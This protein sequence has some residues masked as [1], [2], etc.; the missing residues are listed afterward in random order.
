MI[1]LHT[2][3]CLSDGLLSPLELV[4][5]ASDNGVKVMAITDH[6]AI[7][8]IDAA[9]ARA[10]E[11]GITLVNGI[12][13]SVAEHTHIIGLFIKDF[14]YIQKISKIRGDYMRESLS[15][16][17][18]C[19][20]DNPI[21]LKSARDDFIAKWQHKNPAMDK[22]LIIETLLQPPF[23]AGE[24]IDLIHQSGGLAF[25]AH[26]GRTYNTFDQESLPG[27][28][29]RLIALGL[30]GIEVYQSEQSE[31]F[32][33]FCLNLAKSKK[34]LISGGSDFHKPNWN[35]FLGKY[36]TTDNAKPIPESVWENLSKY[37]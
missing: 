24:A 11:L 3:S 33:D 21:Q 8:N 10:Q 37:L 19:G 25:M 17:G 22:T 7:H 4:Q 16:A 27:Y 15:R 20:L 35:R 12:E 30:D 1:D 29:D 23:G 36:G 18:Y 32:T 26:L 34:L 28:L 14:S 9:K 31:E 5:Y 13:L 6:N 2:H